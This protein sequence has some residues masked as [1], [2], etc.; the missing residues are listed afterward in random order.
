MFV[1]VILSHMCCI[2]TKYHSTG[3]FSLINTSHQVTRLFMDWNSPAIKSGLHGEIKEVL[4][5]LW[6]PIVTMSR[7]FSPI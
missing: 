4:N 7:T 3:A 5:P 1:C 2:P 6:L